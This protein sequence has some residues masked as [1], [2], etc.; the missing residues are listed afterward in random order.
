MRS[1]WCYVV[2][3]AVA[4]IPRFAAAQDSGT[5]AGAVTDDT[6]IPLLGAEVVADSGAVR[7]FTNSR[8]AF[9]LLIAQGNHTLHVRRLGFAPLEVPVAV[10]AGAR[11]EVALKLKSVAATLPPVVVNPSNVHY[12]G[13]L[14]GY[15]Q[16]L[17]KGTGGVF[18]T[19]NQID[20]ENPSTLGQLLQHVPGITAQ[21]G[22][23]GIT[24][25]RMRGRTCWPLVWI[26]GTPM[27]AGETD[28]DAF[29]P[30]SLQGIEL[31]LGST[32]APMRYIYNRDLS[33]CGTILLWSRGPD[34]DPV[35]SSA[36]NAVDLASLVNQQVVFKANQVDRR[37]T[38]D[39][40]IDLQLE[41]P[42]S[43]FAAG[44]QGLVIAEF[45]VDTAGKVEHETV[46]IVS[47]TDALFSSAVRAALNTASYIPALKAGKPVRQL[48]QQP[49]RFTPGRRQR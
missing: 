40:A 25:V 42:P 18:I 45:V 7:T 15:Y 3:A 14:A 49:F 48:V 10:A 36:D 11:A 8:G 27:P 22:R 39:T 23:H 6:G 34:T 46:G 33:S 4:L 30:S 12:T 9:V 28:L 43:L 5:I 21:R 29:V 35:G 24:S 41:F 44:V 26:D 1:P 17:E 31:Y 47:S 37:A 20:R 13:R 32:T 16:R 2:G 38:L 19:R